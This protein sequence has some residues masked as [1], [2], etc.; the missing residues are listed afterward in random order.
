LNLCQKV[1][2]V[3]MLDCNVPGAHFSKVPKSMLLRV[4]IFL[5]GHTISTNHMAPPN[6]LFT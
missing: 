2:K 4:V 1:L 3:T 6:I 5:G